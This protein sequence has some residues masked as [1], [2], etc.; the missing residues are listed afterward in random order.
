MFNVNNWHS[1]ETIRLSWDFSSIFPNMFVQHPHWLDISKNRTIIYLFCWAL[2]LLQIYTIVVYWHFFESVIL[3]IS[4]SKI[5]FQF[6]FYR[7]RFNCFREIYHFV[8]NSIV[9]AKCIVCWRKTKYMLV[10]FECYGLFVM[11]WCQDDKALKC[12]C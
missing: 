3:F 11:P 7:N 2:N 6:S 4:V 1:I 5:S 12:L 10:V 8:V 9:I